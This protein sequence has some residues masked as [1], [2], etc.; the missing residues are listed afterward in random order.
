MSS[1]LLLSQDNW[2][3]VID[4]SGN[5]AAAT[6]PYSLAQDV[7]SA[8]RV[9]TGDIWYDTAQGIAY[10][11]RVLGQR[12]TNQFLKG[13]IEARALTVPGVVSARCLFVALQDRKLSG[14]VQI[15]D[16][17]GASNNVSF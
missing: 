17:T 8:V 2:D 16:T 5:I 15:I 13:Q 7:A 9:F 12:P 3:L 1:T 6:D 14:Q 4:T 10:L 11:T